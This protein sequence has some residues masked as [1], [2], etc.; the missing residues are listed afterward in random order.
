MKEGKILDCIFL[1]QKDFPRKMGSIRATEPFRPGT[2]KGL[3]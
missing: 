2:E 3:P 1:K